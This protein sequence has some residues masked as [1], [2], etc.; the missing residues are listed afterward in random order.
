MSI[1]FR[2]LQERLRERLLAQIEAGELTGL[3]LARETGFQ[4]AHISNFLNRKRGLSLEAMDAILK[5]TQTP[6]MELMEQAGRVRSRRSAALGECPG[7]VTFPI[8]ELENCTAV[9]MPNSGS[10]NAIKIA[11]PNVQKLRAQMETPRGH[12]QR[13]IA[14]RVSAADAVAMYPRLT[15]GAMAG[16][17]RHYNSLASLRKER[18]MYLVRWR[19]DF[20]LRYVEKVGAELIARAEQM[21]EPLQRLEEGMPSIIGRV[22]W[23]YAD[24]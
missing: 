15:R 13:F 5:A 6:L 18:N 19:S 8:V 22:C 7:F 24:V 17:D 14:V 21:A 9:Q 3:Q 4:Q 1:N 11:L 10:P 12:W 20:M 2:S 16:I 23:I